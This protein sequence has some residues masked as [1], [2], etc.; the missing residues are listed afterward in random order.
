MLVYKMSSE[1]EANV[2]QQPLCEVLE[3]AIPDDAWTVSLIFNGVSVTA[4]KKVE[5]WEWQL[6]KQYVESFGTILFS[7]AG[8]HLNGKAA[9]P[10]IHY[11]FIIDRVLC[12]MPPANPSDHRK[13]FCTKEGMEPFPK[14]VTVQFKKIEPDKPKYSCLSYPLKEGLGLPDTPRLYFAF[15]E[16]MKKE[17]FKFL[18]EYGKGIYD[19]EVANNLRRDKCDERKKNALMAMHEYCVAGRS[20]FDDLRSMRKYLDAYIQKLELTEKPKFSNYL[21]NC[22]AIASDLGIL[23]YSDI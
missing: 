6:A 22:H 19:V 8:L 12:K 11:C 9:K 7:S 18:K 17:V 13:R 2:E 15:G 4:E 21:A 20:E 10:H 23:K 14:G 3:A 5:Q 1:N 16:P